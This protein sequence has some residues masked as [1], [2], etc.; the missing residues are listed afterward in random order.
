VATAKASAAC[1]D[2]KLLPLKGDFPPL[3]K[4]SLNGVDHFAFA[5]IFQLFYD[6]LAPRWPKEYQEEN[7]G[8]A[9]TQHRQ[10]RQFKP[11]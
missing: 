1:P 10:R 6:G 11:S 4:V 5:L 7:G 9:Q 8:K 2:G 3:K